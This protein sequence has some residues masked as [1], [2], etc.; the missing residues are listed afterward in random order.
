MID[1]ITQFHKRRRPFSIKVDLGVQY[2]V[3]FLHFP[4][5]VN[6]ALII[7]PKHGSKLMSEYVITNY[8]AN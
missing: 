6:Y 1:R 5:Y 4:T 7:C 3:N 8:I 2:Y